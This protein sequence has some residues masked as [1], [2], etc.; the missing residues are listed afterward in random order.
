MRVLV[1]RCHR[2]LYFINA[3]IRPLYAIHCFES[4]DTNWSL[5]KYSTNLSQ[6][7]VGCCLCTASTIW[8]I[9]TWKSLYLYK[10]NIFEIPSH[11]SSSIQQNR[12][13][14]TAC[15][16]FSYSLFFFLASLCL[17]VLVLWM[18]WAA[19]ALFLCP[20]SSVHVFV[21]VSVLIWLALDASLARTEKYAIDM[22]FC[23]CTLHSH[24]Q[25]EH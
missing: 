2:F 19:R 4:I 17:I 22:F 8:Y 20:C 7:V 16:C 3:F 9:N 1:R 21:S 12:M 15:H 14:T 6:M 23:F 10:L 11:C 24:T 13:T 5:N 25:I 18:T